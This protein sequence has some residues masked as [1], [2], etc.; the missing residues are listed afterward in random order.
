MTQFPHSSPLQAREQLGLRGLPGRR[1]VRASPGRVLPTAAPADG[2]PGQVQADL[3]EGEILQEVR[4]AGQGVG[5]QLAG[6]LRHRG[7]LD[8]L[9]QHPQFR[10]I[11]QGCLHSGQTGLSSLVV[12]SILRRNVEGARCGECSWRSRRAPGAGLL[13]QLLWDQQVERYRGEESG[14]LLLPRRGQC[15][16]SDSRRSGGP[17]RGSDW[18]KS[19]SEPGKEPGK[20]PGTGT[21]P[22]TKLWE[23]SCK[24]NRNCW[25]N[26]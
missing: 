25:F 22:G 8:S 14:H 10:Q 19:G 24:L 4:P 17:A 12:K 16:L 2:L 1:S 9:R 15:G 21:G 18:T 13:L 3:E 6:E 5:G 26:Y 7:D 23:E 20:E 11:Q